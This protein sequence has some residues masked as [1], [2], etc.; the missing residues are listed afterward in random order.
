MRVCVCMYARVCMRW[1]AQDA[2]GLEA[3]ATT[4]AGCRTEHKHQSDHHKHQSRSTSGTQRTRI[5]K[6]TTKT[7]ANYFFFNFLRRTFAP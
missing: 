1:M 3:G 6:E 5:A 7:I 2:G 4:R